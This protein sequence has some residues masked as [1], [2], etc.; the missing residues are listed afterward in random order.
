MKIPLSAL[1]PFLLLIPAGLLPGRDGPGKG[2][3]VEGKV[4]FS[5]LGPGMLR[6]EYDP[7]GAFDDRP[8]FRC[9]SMPG[10]RPFERVERKGGVLRLEG[11]GLSI[12]YRPG[13][14]G[15]WKGEVKVAWKAGGMEGTWSPGRVDERNLGSLFTMDHLARAMIPRGVHPAGRDRSDRYGEY[16]LVHA[17]IDVS[18]EIREHPELYGD[19][20]LDFSR[21]FREFDSLPEGL[22]KIAGMW[23]K[24]PPGAVSASGWT[25]IDETGMAFYDPETR[26]IDKRLK[27]GYRNLFFFCYGRDYFRAMRQFTALCGRIPLLPR[28]AFGSWYSC[29]QRYSAEKNQ[30]VIEEYEKNGIP[31]DVLIIDMDW[32]VNG[33]NGWEWNEELYPDL[34]GFFGWLKKKG[35]HAALNL[36][37]ESI[38]RKDAFFKRICERLGVKTDVE[39]PS[40]LKVFAGSDSWI[41]DFTD[42]KVWEAVRDVCY[43][44]N[45][46]LGVSFWWLDNWQGRQ[47]SYNS[48]LWIDHLAFRHMEEDLGRRPVI[49]GR[50]SGFGT[51]RY[52]AC[53]TGDTASQ[54][55]VLAH[56]LEVNSRSAQ[57]GMAYL[58]HDLGG[59]KGPWPGVTLPRIDPELYVRWMQMGA[60]SPIM[61]IHSDHGTREPWEYG[62]NVLRI[63]DAVKSPWLGI[64]MDTGKRSYNLAAM[65]QSSGFSSEMVA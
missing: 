62:E 29:F 21:F 24:F 11:P 7:D 52:G 55:E 22:R 43:V 15:P 51:H 53:F 8:T 41:L 13:K 16:N 36:H 37:D 5:L 2:P 65:E 27:P 23:L 63:V 12:R 9:I 45:E 47:E 30:E 64:N 44:P 28:W 35:I 61:R 56:E 59:F 6:I 26:W 49:L 39:N 14:G 25:V 17:W 38:N 46:K 33:W 10:A 57:V 48:V 34:P 54:W 40:D 1:L 50:Y 32:H 20:H 42:R 3:V 4:R 58:S 31:L 19:L 18:R 60:L